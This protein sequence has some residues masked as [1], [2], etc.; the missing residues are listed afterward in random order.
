MT[1]VATKHTCHARGCEKEIPERLLMCLRHWNLVPVDLKL[2]VWRTY[3]EGQE[4][5][6]QPSPEYLEVARATSARR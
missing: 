5:D 2:A 3:R 4:I 6:K 1:T